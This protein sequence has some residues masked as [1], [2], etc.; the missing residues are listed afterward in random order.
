MRG[1]RG[2]GYDPVF[3]F[4]GFGATFAEVEAERKNRVSHRGQALETLA[5]S[6]EPLLT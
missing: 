6:L 4:P 3:C 1:E 2:F 5:K